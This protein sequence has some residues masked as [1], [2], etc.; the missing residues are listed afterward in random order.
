MA[1]GPMAHKADLRR[2][3]SPWG[4]RGR[5][6]NGARG[7]NRA[8]QCNPGLQCNRRP[9]C[10]PALQCSRGPQWHPGPQCNR[11]PQPRPGPQANRGRPDPITA[12]RSDPCLIKARGDFSKLPAWEKG[13]VWGLWPR[14]FRFKP[15]FP[16]RDPWFFS[17]AP[18]TLRCF[19]GTS[20]LTWA[21]LR[22]TEPGCRAYLRQ[23]H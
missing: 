6:R 13:P 3:S 5:C 2:K 1:R 23:P 14:L 16:V 22:V 20:P 15:G 18:V 7:G 12:A 11:A 8:P 10:N 4:R 9:P 17:P 21:M 19:A